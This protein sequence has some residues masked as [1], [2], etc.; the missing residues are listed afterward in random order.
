V[1]TIKLHLNL[2][3]NRATRQDGPSVCLFGSHGQVHFSRVGHVQTNVW[4]E[5][6]DATARGIPKRNN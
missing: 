4:D 6:K 2:T 1:D 3:E 5:K